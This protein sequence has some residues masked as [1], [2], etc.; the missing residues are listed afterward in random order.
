MYPFLDAE[1]PQLRNISKGINAY[2]PKPK[3]GAAKP[4][5]VSMQLTEIS[6]V[7]RALDGCNITMAENLEDDIDDDAEELR[8]SLPDNA[9]ELRESLRDERAQ[10]RERALEIQRQWAAEYDT[11]H[12][13]RTRF[14][15]SRQATSTNQSHPSMTSLEE[16]DTRGPR[17]RAN[18]L[19]DPVFKSGTSVESYRHNWHC[20]P[21]PLSRE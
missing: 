4:L 18:M 11:P 8:E 10:T 12:K 16:E 20:T 19:K 15:S 13:S 14:V 1:G 21:V 7:A 6:D 3:P 5:N 9:E 17:S 2:L